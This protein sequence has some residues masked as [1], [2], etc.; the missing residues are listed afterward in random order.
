MA[1]ERLLI[2]CKVCG[3]HVLLLKSL[4]LGWYSKMP[5]ATMREVVEFTNKHM[6]CDQEV[7]GGVV[8]YGSAGEI[9]NISQLFEIVTESDLFTA[10]SSLAGDVP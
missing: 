9:T 3:H 2:R 10:D 6:L 5:S 4:A 8:T 1:N 7:P